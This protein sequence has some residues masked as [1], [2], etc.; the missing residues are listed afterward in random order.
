[1]FG[2]AQPS[3]A[4]TTPQKEKGS[5]NAFQPSRRNSTLAACLDGIMHCYLGILIKS[6]P[7]KAGG[8]QVTDF[9]KGKNIR[10]FTKFLR[11][12]SGGCQGDPG[13]LMFLFVVFFCFFCVF[14]FVFCFCFFCCFCFFLFFLFLCFFFV[15]GFLLKSRFCSPAVAQLGMSSC[16]LRLAS[17]FFLPPT[18]E[19]CLSTIVVHP[20]R[21]IV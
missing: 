3:P 21:R 14:V 11:R 17:C 5:Q 2:T 8:T 18:E 9:T 6:S 20:T 4:K 15:R 1:M 10:I 13:P 12:R 16:H 19:D 7:P